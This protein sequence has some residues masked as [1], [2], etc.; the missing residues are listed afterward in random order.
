MVSQCKKLWSFAYSQSELSKP[1][2]GLHDSL[3]FLT[4]PHTPAR[5]LVPGSRAR[6]DA[7]C[8]L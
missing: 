6:L 7:L 4:T 8:V 1:H 2:N 3:P 5:V